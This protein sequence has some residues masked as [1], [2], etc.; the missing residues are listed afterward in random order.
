MKSF[1]CYST[2]YRV[3]KVWTSLRS[4]V[5]QLRL[6]LLSC[7]WLQ[8]SPSSYSYHWVGPL[9]DSFWSH[10][11]RCLFA[12]SVRKFSSK[13]DSLLGCDPYTSVCSTLLTNCEDGGSRFLWMTNCE[14]GGSRFLWNN[15][16]HL[17]TYVSSHPNTFHHHNLISHK[18]ILV[19]MGTWN[20]VHH[21]TKNKNPIIK[22]TKIVHLTYVI[23]IFYITCF[24]YKIWFKWKVT[25]FMFWE[26]LSDCVFYITM[27]NKLYTKQQGIILIGPQIKVGTKYL[28]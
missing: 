9:V 27:L 2:W 11:S 20:I 19:F 15:G 1:K 12:I 13:D 5:P 10:A 16:T 28:H 23:N 3:W 26:M 17:P 7:T 21:Q 18:L 6:H 25:L 24:C 4:S 14:D 8:S 22:I